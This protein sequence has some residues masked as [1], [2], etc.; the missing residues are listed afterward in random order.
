MVGTFV[1]NGYLEAPASV[2]RQPERDM[3][4]LIAGCPIGPLTPRNCEHS[5]EL[6]RL[7][8]ASWQLLPSITDAQMDALCRV[9]AASDYARL[10]AARLA[11]IAFAKVQIV[12]CRPLLNALH[13]QGLNY[14]LLKGGATAFL[15]YPEP[16]MRGAWDIDIGVD[17]GD[18]KEAEA[19]AL[20]YGY[21][22]AQQ[23]RETNRFF[24]ADTR[25]KASVEAAHYE[26]GFLVRRFQITNLPPATV[27]AIRSEPFTHQYWFDTANDFP[28]CYASVDIHHAISLDIPLRDLLAHARTVSFGGDTLRVPDDA[29]LMAHLVFKI[30]WEGVHNYG[31]CLYEY[32]DLVRLVPHI[33]ERDFDRMVEILTIY[34]LLA[35]GHYVFRRLH[36]FGIEVP[37]RF[38]GFIRETGVP[39]LQA[40][41]IR[42]NDLGDMWPKIWG[43]R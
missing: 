4:S 14:S 10:Q 9:L 38:A 3:L 33:S 28:C 30:Y 36:L 27:E 40:D 20:K 37:P 43:R 11:L 24:R 18:L 8:F 16:H 25:L 2:L 19:L 7:L 41:P 39:P 34:N 1:G 12:A 21:V 32:A 13:E 35:A 5:G 26:L 22:S 6:L 42:I 23:D 31:K 17:R 15:L 29:W